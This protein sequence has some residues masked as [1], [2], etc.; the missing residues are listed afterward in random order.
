MAVKNV[1]KNGCECQQC[2]QKW[3]RMGFETMPAAPTKDVFWYRVR[4]I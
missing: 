1:G 4:G 3:L 2:Q